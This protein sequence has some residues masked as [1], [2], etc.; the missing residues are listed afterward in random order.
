[1]KD[2]NRIKELG[3]VFT[4]PELVNEILDQLPEE[5]WQEHKT[6]CDPS[7]GNGNFLVEVYKRKVE[8]YGHHPVKA[9]MTIYGVEIMEDNVLECQ[10]RLLQ[11]ARKYLGNEYNKYRRRILKILKKNIVCADALKYDFSFKSSLQKT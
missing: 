10:A 7:A 4:P 8:K 5:V 6:F 9:L 11:L 2:R 1:M 3:E